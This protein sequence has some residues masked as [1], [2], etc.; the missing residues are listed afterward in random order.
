[1]QMVSTKASCWRST[2]LSSTRGRHTGGK[3]KTS[4]SKTQQKSCTAKLPDQLSCATVHR[5]CFYAQYTSPPEGSPPVARSTTVLETAVYGNSVKFIGSEAECLDGASPWPLQR[6]QFSSTSY[7][8]LQ[9]G[10][11][12]ILEQRSEVSCLSYN[13]VQRILLKHTRLSEERD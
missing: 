8:H 10:S 2:F 6:I 7:T 13:V 5:H 11:Q 3:H 9:V 4:A 12:P 1:M